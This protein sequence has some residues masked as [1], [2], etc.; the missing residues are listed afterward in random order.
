MRYIQQTERDAMGN[1]PRLD[2]VFR[3][4]IYRSS[5]E[6]VQLSARKTDP[7]VTGVEKST[8]LAE[9]DSIRTRTGSAGDRGGP[10]DFSSSDNRSQVQ[11]V[12]FS[13]LI[14]VINPLQHIPLVSNVYRAVTGDEISNPARIAGSTLFFGPIGAATSI[15]SIAMEEIT[16]K[17][18]GD[19]VVSLL[20]GDAFESAEPDI[21]ADAA[22]PDQGGNRP[23]SAALN[24]AKLPAS[25][26]GENERLSPDKP[27]SFIG[28]DDTLS[29]SPG[30][31]QAIGFAPPTEPVSLDALPADILAALYSGQPVRPSKLD[32]LNVDNNHSEPGQSVNNLSNSADQAPE[33]DAAPRWNLWAAPDSTLASHSKAVQA[34]GGVVPNESISAGGIASQGGWF[35][36]S[37]PEVLARYHDT[38]SLQRQAVRPYVDVS[39]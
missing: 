15:A 18:V 5:A 13:D 9:L 31:P 22:A 39:Q 32:T 12:S 14:D 28:N 11:P 33:F 3:P 27:F 36:A 29:A 16:G 4:Q 17:D 6:P 34:Y 38:A 37:M 10:T 8:A 2:S 21:V 23:S 25:L 1:D 19:H 20:S 35:G 7:T 24:D 30:T 26:T